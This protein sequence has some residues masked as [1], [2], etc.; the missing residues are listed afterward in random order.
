M[1]CILCIIL[2]RLV[3]GSS[4]NEGRLE[5]CYNG[6]C[7]A[8]CFDGW[9]D[10]Y[11]GLMC[12]QLGFGQLGKSAD[13]SPGTGAILMEIAMCSPNITFPDSCIHYGIGI[14]VKCNHHKEIGIKCKGA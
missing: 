2:V 4:Y 5:V 7:G 11:A 14:T 10:N 8:L 3:D 1:L 6:R 9:N 13:F 12:A